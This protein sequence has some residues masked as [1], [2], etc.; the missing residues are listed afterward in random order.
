MIANVYT[1]KYLVKLCILINHAMDL[2]HC[3]M[4]THTIGYTIVDGRMITDQDIVKEI[5]RR[6]TGFSFCNNGSTW[7]WKPNNEISYEFVNF[8]LL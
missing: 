2:G 8:N 3:N 5:E 6:Y 4:R 1:E 7:Y